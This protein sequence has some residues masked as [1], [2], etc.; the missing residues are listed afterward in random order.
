MP[1]KKKNLKDKKTDW[2]LFEKLSFFYVKKII[3]EKHFNASADKTI[4]LT[5]ATKDGGY[6][7]IWHLSVAGIDQTYLMESKLRKS[8]SSLSLN[9]CAKAIIIAFNYPAQKLYITTNLTFSNQALE[10]IQKMKISTNLDIICINGI[11]LAQFVKDNDIRLEK[12]LGKEFLNQFIDLKFKYDDLVDLKQNDG[13]RDKI[14]IIGKKHN[15]YAKKVL[16]SLKSSLKSKLIAGTEGVGKSHILKYIKKNLE[17]DNIRVQSV[18]MNLETSPT[19]VFMRILE[20]LW[21]IELL[22]L[23]INTP[24][25]ELEKILNIN[26]KEIDSEIIKAVTYSLYV[27]QR[28]YIDYA[29]KYNSLLLNYLDKILDDRNLRLCF[30]FHNTEKA[31]DEVQ[32]FLYYLI[33]VLTAKKIH[34]IIEYRIIGLTTNSLQKF[35]K[36]SELFL[37]ENFELKDASNYIYDQIDKKMSLKTCE[38][39]AEQLNCNP[40]N[41][42]GAIE[43]LNNQ[44]SYFF[45][46]IKFERKETRIREILLEKGFTNNSLF[47]S[48]VNE[49]RKQ[50]NGDALLELFLIFKG[51]IPIEI[52]NNLIQEDVQNL[53]KMSNLLHF[54]EAYIICHI[55]L[56]PFIENTTNVVLAF[57][58]A[59][60]ML[61]I[62]YNYDDHAKLN[63]LYAA[64]RFNDIPTYTLN[65]MKICKSENAFNEI[66]E[67]GVKCLDSVKIIDLDIKLEILL[68]LFESLLELHDLSDKYKSYYNEL[69]NEI[70]NK[71]KYSEFYLRFILISWENNFNRGKF[72]LAKDNIFPFYRNVFRIKRHTK[73]YRGRIINAYG[74]T[75]KELDNG[76]ESLKLFRRFH[77]LFPKSYFIS[78]AFYSQKGN[79]VLKENAKK[80]ERYYDLLLKAVKERD[81]PKQ[82]IIHARVD[83]AMCFLLNLIKTHNNEL[84]RTFQ[85]Y[86]EETIEIVDKT[87]VGMQEGRLY[88]YNGIFLIYQNKYEAAKLYLQNAVKYLTEAQ[89]LIYMWRAEFTLVSLL[90]NRN[91]NDYFIEIKEGLD[92]VTNILRSHFLNKIK[93]DIF[94]VAY[95]VLLNCC[96]YYNEL[97]YAE[98]VEDILK[99]VDSEELKEN[100]Y[101]LIHNPNWKETFSSKVFCVNGIM[102]SVG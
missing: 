29:D 77:F 54:D 39:L 50:K 49:L 40:L 66:V 85:D 86:Y 61:K 73:D 90:F 19:T 82:Q 79:I 33:N 72:K 16:N 5:P 59:K 9:D 75:M 15:N 48:L 25:T 21:N 88:L 67:I 80:A 78:A 34:T 14:L 47:P 60:Q 99:F 8:Q 2:R 1:G 71:S 89:A 81:Y 10:N 58:L 20:K 95:L 37:I 7:A 55:S 83:K 94:S 51:R 53:V 68:L 97:G 92:N 46:Q 4:L 41:I 76:F 56:L 11:Q 64:R 12:L 91:K 35:E 17:N 6:D 57:R 42:T 63:I 65:Y 27:N 24:K 45:E 13:Y 32:D 69:S 31:S 98:I 52:L 93:K 23:T 28:D 84:I 26:Q 70:Q 87:N 36:N 96:I 62:D 44:E 22:G 38:I 43:K 100:Y 102:V 74:L 18:D 101:R 3:S 30:I